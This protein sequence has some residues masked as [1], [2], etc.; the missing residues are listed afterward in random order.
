MG[1]ATRAIPFVQF[2]VDDVAPGTKRLPEIPVAKAL[3]RTVRDKVLVSSHSA[4]NVVDEGDFHPLIAAAAIAYQQH[5]PLV[6][7]PDAL[8]ITVLQGVAQHLNYNS[9]V[10]RPRLVQHQ[11]KIELVVNSNLFSLAR[12]EGEMLPAV[13]EFATRI[14]SHVHPDKRFL[15][16]TRFSTT[17][18]VDQIVQYIVLMDAFQP[19]FDYVFA[20][21]CGI[22]SV[23]L[24]GSPA[25]W[26][27]LET[28][29]QALHETDLGLTWWTERL[30][31]LCRQ[32]VR[33]SRGDVDLKHWRDICKLK[34]KYGFN[35]LN[36]W[37]LKF[38]PYVRKDKNEPPVHRNPVMNRMEFSFEDNNKITGCTSDMLPTGISSAPV[39]VMNMSTGKSEQFQFV[40]GFTGVVQSDDLSLKPALGWAI[41]D[42]RRIDKLIGRVRLEHSA[43]PSAGLSTEELLKKFDGY[44]PA[45][46]WRFYSEVGKASFK[47]NKPN[48]WGETRVTI[49][50]LSFVQKIWDGD[51]VRDELN[52][53]GKEGLLSPNDLKERLDFNFEHHLLLIIGEG[54]IPH[55]DKFG[56]R[57]P[58]YLFGRDPCRY[59]AD[60]TERDRGVIFRWDGRNRSPEAFIPVAHTFPDWL[61]ELLDG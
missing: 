6:L 13:R 40:G 56:P 35:D 52:F 43:S 51:S 9:K 27:L 31:P 58:L 26:E 36:G 53:L 28:K 10:L 23:T 12:N 42:G 55:K 7:T 11:T 37:L 5:F 14:A 3:E 17:G 20:I 49:R 34:A 38:I 44:L 39:T 25:D 4:Q 33:A 50:P 59:R 46:L 18:E 30:L 24:E 19:Y 29:V 45:D 16:E 41:A 8:W 1:E 47:F 54:D 22:P 2:A 57:S 48:R 61:T 21:I 15:F 60:A 32:F